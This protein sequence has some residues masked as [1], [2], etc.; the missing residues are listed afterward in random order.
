MTITPNKVEN[1]GTTSAGK[2]TAAE[3]N[4]LA[5]GVID[6]KAAATAALGAA[7]GFNPADV[8]YDL[9]P[10]LGQSNDTG[11]GAGSPDVRLD[12]VDPRVWSFD[13]AGPYAGVIRQAADPLGH[14]SGAGVGPGMAFARRMIRTLP[15]NRSIL[16]IPGGT[17][18]SNISGANG[19]NPTGGPLLPAVV[20]QVVAAFAA[21]DPA[22]RAASRVAAI[23]WGQGEG[24]AQGNVSQ[25]VYS[26][27]L[28]DL[29]NY[30]RTNLPTATASTPFVIGG[31]VPEVISVSAGTF[32]AIDAAHRAFSTKRAFTAY[33]PG[34]PGGYNQDQLHYNAV[35]CRKLGTATAALA[36]P[37]ALANTGATAQTFPALPGA[38]PGLAVSASGTVTWTGAVSGADAYL[39]EYR[40]AGTTN[41]STITI[42]NPATLTTSVS[43]LAGTSYELRGRAY[44]RGGLGPVSTT[45]T[46]GTSGPT[47]VAANNFNQADGPVG[48]GQIGPAPT[49]FGNPVISS[50][51]LSATGSGTAVWDAGAGDWT[52]QITFMLN[53]TGASSIQICPD[54]TGAGAVRWN[55]A[56]SVQDNAFNSLGSTGNG[57]TPGEVLKVKKVGGQ[58]TFYRNGTQV[59][60]VTPT[61]LTLNSKVGVFLGEDKYDDM[62]LTAP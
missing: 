2:L 16:A 15:A 45:L 50:G 21:M 13:A 55:Q 14:P 1:G 27:L 49:K 43:A 60:Q 32:A 56:G 18:G 37:L 46:F 47:P 5:Q 39:I 19:W 31:M 11:S 53:A 22:T 34:V 42:T 40:V 26:G 30:L 48:A 29:V 24:D 54:G 4:E 7:S 10:F 62:T 33:E 57:W 59:L 36:L 51:S 41:W 61:G 6:A 3:Y 28:V 8:G 38:L 52:F 25:S 44:N 35:G 9:V 17:G 58:F 20:A 23:Y 12:P